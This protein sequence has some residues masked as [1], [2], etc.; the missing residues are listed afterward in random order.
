MTIISVILAYQMIDRKR[1]IMFTKKGWLIMLFL[2]L[3]AIIES[4]LIFNKLLI[5]KFLY[6][7][8]QNLLIS[9]FVTPLLIHNEGFSIHQK[10]QLKWMITG[11]IVSFLPTTATSVTPITNFILEGK[12]RPAVNGGVVPF[13]IQTVLI[14]LFGALLFWVF[15]I[16]VSAF[17]GLFAKFWFDKPRK[18]NDLTQH[19]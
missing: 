1:I 9:I 17:A 16:L 8:I 18:R 15:Q 4:I 11:V 5:V 3:L 7:L 10:P 13:T 6:I 2:L 14:V 12:G 19:Q